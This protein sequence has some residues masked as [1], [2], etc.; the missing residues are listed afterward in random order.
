MTK[1]TRQLRE[2]TRP[3]AE[4]PGLCHPALKCEI[5]CCFV[6]CGLALT[7]VFQPCDLSGCK[8]Q[9]NLHPISKPIIQCFQY[10]SPSNIQCFLHPSNIHTGRN[11]KRLPPLAPRQRTLP[12]CSE[13][14]NTKARC[15]NRWFKSNLRNFTTPFHAGCYYQ[16]PSLTGPLEGCASYRAMQGPSLLNLQALV[17][18]S[19]FGTLKASTL[20]AC[21]PTPGG[22]KLARS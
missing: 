17:P 22:C 11:P 14:P 21:T 18:S 15:S 1:G 4:G 7:E 20:A 10:P 3:V 9:A 2:G 6:I 8:G 12:H 13:T 5:G 16:Q 19:P